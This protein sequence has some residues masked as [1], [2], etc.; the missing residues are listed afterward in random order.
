MLG[1]LLT[2]ASVYLLFKK[3]LLCV[4]YARLNPADSGRGGNNKREK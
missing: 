4:F 1:F 2:K 3:R